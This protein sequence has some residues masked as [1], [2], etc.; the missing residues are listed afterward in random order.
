[1]RFYIVEDDPNIVLILKQILSDQNLGEVIGVAHDGEKALKEIPGLQPDIVLVDLFIPK[2][3]GLSLLQKLNG[4]ITSIMISQVSAKDMIGRAYEAGVEFF[5]QKPINAIEVISVIRNVKKSIDAERK[6]SQIKSMF[7]VEMMESGQTAPS[8]ANTQ[9]DNAFKKDRVVEALRSIGVLGES[10]AD[11][12]LTAVHYLMDHPNALNEMSL[13]KFF[14]HF[15]KHPKSFE[16]KIRRTAAIALNNLAYMGLDDY[17]NLVFQDYAHVLFA[18]REVRVEMDGIKAQ[19][20]THGS[21]NIRKF[22]EGMSHI[23]TSDEIFF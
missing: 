4:T 19:N 7:A 2:L 13:K 5:I 14:N 6:L 18:F 8:S 1:M 15:S 17:S 20:D 22:L 12:I 11:A 9:L 23:C 10:G 16:Q 3:D 21:V